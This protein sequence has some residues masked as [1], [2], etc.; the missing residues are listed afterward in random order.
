MQQSVNEIMAVLLTGLLQ[1]SHPTVGMES[2]FQRA[3]HI[4]LMSSF[5]CPSPA[6]LCAT[7]RTEKTHFLAIFRF[8]N[9]AAQSQLLYGYKALQATC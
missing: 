2:T 4:S 1:G 8:R 9:A 7:L 5:M 3:I 6:L